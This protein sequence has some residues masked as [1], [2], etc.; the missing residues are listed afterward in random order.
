M[1]VN[2]WIDLWDKLNYLEVEKQAYSTMKAMKKYR[3]YIIKSHSV[4]IVPRNVV[5]SLL[6]EREL[7][8]KH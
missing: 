5:R 7:G 4:D 6:M 3:S 1:I 2:N 8:E